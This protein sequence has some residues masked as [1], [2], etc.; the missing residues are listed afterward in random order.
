MAKA[1]ASLLARVWSTLNRTKPDR[2]SATRAS[3]P[4]IGAPGRDWLDYAGL[5][6]QAARVTEALHA[7]GEI[8]GVE[9]RQQQREPRLLATR[10]PV[11]H[12]FRLVGV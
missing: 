8:G 12:R 6:A 9:G 7:A 5:K 2:I 1:T 3:A 10:Q 4:A 11:D